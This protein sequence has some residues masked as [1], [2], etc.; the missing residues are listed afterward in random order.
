MSKMPTFSLTYCASAPTIGD[1]N[2]ADHS[3]RAGVGCF[4]TKSL[5]DSNH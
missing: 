3:S 5:F 1:Q 2:F 4:A